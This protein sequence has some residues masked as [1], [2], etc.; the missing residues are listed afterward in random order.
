MAET[1]AA[2]SITLI[3]MFVLCSK[4][5]MDNLGNEEMDM[6]TATTETN[7]RLK[8]RQRCSF[9]TEKVSVTTSRYPSVNTF[10]RRNDV[11]RT[12][13]KVSVL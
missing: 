7:E 1:L 10:L 6:K 13:A 2:M 9:Q 8:C 11:C 12:V 3:S 5:Y 4:Y